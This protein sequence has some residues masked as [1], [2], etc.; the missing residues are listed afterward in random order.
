MR[1]KYIALEGP[2]GVGKTSLVNLMVERLGAAKILEDVTNPFLEAFYEEEP[3]AA[4]QAQLFY[5]LARYRTL[6]EAVQTDLFSRFTVAD[7]TFYK[8]RI[9]AHLTLDDSELLLYEKLWAVLEPQVPKPDLVVYLQGST[10]VLA[11]RVAKRDRAEE[12][13]LSLDYLEEV[14]QAFSHFF[15]QYDDTPLLVINTT[16]IDFVADPVDFDDLIAQIESMD[17][18]RQVYVPRRSR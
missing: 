1:K 17:A 12:R 9:F 6:S 5:L 11:E 2:I 13:N 18:G 3:G 15:L 7:F 14:H 10:A 8:D 4:F 16:D